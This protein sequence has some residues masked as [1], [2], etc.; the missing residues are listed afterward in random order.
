MIQLQFFLFSFGD[1]DKN[2]LNKK[3]IDGEMTEKNIIRLNISD[4]FRLV[5]AGGEAHVW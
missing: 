4:L 3:G 1:G 2:L 5:G